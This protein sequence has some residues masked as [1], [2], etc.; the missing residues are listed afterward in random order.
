MVEEARAFADGD[1]GDG[2]FMV[3]LE[4]RRDEP[5]IPDDLPPET[6]PQEAE[7]KYDVSTGIKM[8]SRTG[9]PFMALGGHMNFI[10]Y[11]GTPVWENLLL[12]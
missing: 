9:I 3:N 6:D 8:I 5:L 2:F 1:N 12:V 10:D 11:E 7:N 4:N